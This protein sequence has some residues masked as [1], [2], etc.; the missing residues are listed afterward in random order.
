MK[1]KNLLL[2]NSTSEQLTEKLK[3]IKHDSEKKERRFFKNEVLNALQQ[4]K[5]RTKK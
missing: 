3:I 1:F 2:E 5:E 4:I